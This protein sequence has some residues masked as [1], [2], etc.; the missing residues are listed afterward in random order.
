VL[1]LVGADE[2]PGYELRVVYQLDLTR[3]QGGGTLEAAKHSLVFGHVV[4]RR[5][6]PLSQLIDDL[7]VAL[8]YDDADCRWPRISSR[9]SVDVND[10]PTRRGRF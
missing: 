2:L 6:D 10:Q 8:G 1:D 3:S 4:C 9:A 5:S 7:A